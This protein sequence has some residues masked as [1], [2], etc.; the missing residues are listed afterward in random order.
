MEE[1]IPDAFKSTVVTPLIKKPNLPSHDLKNYHPVSG[2]SF[3]SKLVGRV[4]AKQL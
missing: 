4:V 2:L 3:I 1:C